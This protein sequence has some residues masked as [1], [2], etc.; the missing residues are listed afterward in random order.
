MAIPDYQTLM[1]PVLEVLADGEERTA[2]AVRRL[3][4]SALGIT[5]EEREEM[6]PS[7]KQGLFANRVGWAGTYLHKAGLVERPRRGVIRI[8]AAGKGILASHDGRIDNDVLDQ[9][10][11]FRDFRERSRSEKSIDGSSENTTN[12][13]EASAADERTPEEAMEAALA[14]V[15]D[16]LAA[17]LLDLL[18]SSSPEFFEQVVI[19]V[20]LAMGYGGSHAEAGERLGQSGDAGVDGVIRE[21]VLGLDAIYVQAKRWA[22][23]RTV[24]RPDVQ[25]FVGALHGKRASKGVFI[26]T[27]TF[28]REALDYVIGL[29]PRVVL[30]DGTRLARLMI[31]YAVGITTRQTFDL[32][33]ID[34]DYFEEG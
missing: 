21:D 22:V 23:H 24:G 7:G 29:T 28:S 25:G 20:L 2:A 19:D 14:Q 10:D 33:R 13:S 3:V 5:A 15:N 16:S 18:V 4:A 9:F 34:S 8:S 11:Q 1:R 6:L 30:I 26:T 17:D 32:K 12:L 27:S 31:R